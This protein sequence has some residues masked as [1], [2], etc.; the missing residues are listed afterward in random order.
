V[1]AQGST[2][3]TSEGRIVSLVVKVAERCNLNCSY[4]Y[5][6]NHADQSYLR[7]PS[8]MS[9][10]VFGQLLSRVDEYCERRPKH[11]MSLVFH[12]GE[13]MLM[14]TERFRRF[15]SL[16]RERLGGKLDSLQLQSN[17]TL[18]DDGWIAT[19]HDLGVTVGVS[20]DGPPAVHDMFRVDHAGN[21]SH[22]RTLNGLL[23]LQESGLLSGSLCV[24][25]PAHSGVDIYRY[26]RSLGITQM[27]FLFP[28]AT[29]DGKRALYGRYGDTPV[30]DYLIPVFDDWIDE[31]NPDVKVSCFEDLI[32]AI[33]GGKVWSDM[34]GNRRANY[35]VID[36]DGSIQALDALKVCSEGTSESGLNLFE[37][38]FDDLHKG[39]PLLHHIVHEG[40]PM[41][42]TCKACPERDTCGG[43]Y[44]PH[45]YSRA[46][47]FDN[48]S[49]W[50]K[51]LLKLFAHVRSYINTTASA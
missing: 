44:L 9:D 15:T 6:Y 37:H 8:F 28:D 47:G 22:E 18:V 42:L 48:P 32:R 34:I 17:A 16:A 29:H 40:I 33:L 24:V 23:R 36:T 45:R 12:G 13:P 38:G 14:G 35:V 51:D 2:K 26:F 27:N 20:L 25:N 46:K 21:G 41:C 1:N 30:A 43:G 39:L 50:C 3:E 5:M 4:C 19:L 31:D 10:E 11:R 49:I 7:R